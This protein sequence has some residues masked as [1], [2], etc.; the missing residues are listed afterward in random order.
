MAYGSTFRQLYPPLWTQG[1]LAWLPWCPW[2]Y[3]WAQTRSSS[4]Q[5]STGMSAW[6]G[7]RLALV[8][9]AGNWPSVHTVE[10]SM[11]TLRPPSAMWGSTSTYFLFVEVATPRAS[12]MGKLSISSWGLCATPCWSLGIRPEPPGSRTPCESRTNITRLQRAEPWDFYL[13]GCGFLIGGGAS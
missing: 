13:P 5:T 11:R 8:E 2:R 10:L 4:W 9:G 12:L 6:W 7:S 1:Y 3:I